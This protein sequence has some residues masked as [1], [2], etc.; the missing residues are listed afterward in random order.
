M[1]GEQKGS[2]PNKHWVA[3]YT[4]IILLPLVYWI[5]PWVSLFFPEEPLAITVLSVAVIVPIVSYLGLPLA[6]KGHKFIQRAL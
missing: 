3:L 5:P 1:S 6:I 2:P 4:F